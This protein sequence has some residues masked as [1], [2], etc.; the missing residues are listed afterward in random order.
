M[1]QRAL[2]GVGGLPKVAIARLAAPA[3]NS[4]PRYSTAGAALV[5]GRVR[6]R[7]RGG[8][9]PPPRAA[10]WCC[11]SCARHL[12]SCAAASSHIS[13]VAVGQCEALA[14]VPWRVCGVFDVLALTEV[15]G[16]AQRNGSSPIKASEGR[17]TLRAP[18]EAFLTVG[19]A[20]LAPRSLLAMRLK[21]L[22]AATAFAVLLTSLAQVRRLF[23]PVSQVPLGR[24][25]LGSPS[26]AHECCTC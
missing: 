6:R 22:A 19:K 8:A 17:C 25:T 21:Q 13:W 3:L 5:Q 10:P 18:L 24:L 15:I 7:R 9:A 14:R 16:R 12:G 2:C 23:A 4:A 26:S 1:P 20:T 11:S